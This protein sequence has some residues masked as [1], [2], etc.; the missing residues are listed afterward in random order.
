L[1]Q[2]GDAKGGK[3]GRVP[4]GGRRGPSSSRCTLSRNGV[5]SR[6][7]GYPLAV[8]RRSPKNC[9]QFRRR[10]EEERN[11]NSLEKQGE[12]LIC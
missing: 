9:D 12:K 5:V 4:G 8:S 1:T 3:N 6:N 10:K 11:M 7:D 2:K